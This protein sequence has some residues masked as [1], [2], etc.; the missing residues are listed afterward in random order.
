MMMRKASTRILRTKSTAI[1]NNMK[2][3]NIDTAYQLMKKHF[4]E[5]KM[6]SHNIR[7]AHGDM[8]IESEG[9]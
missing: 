7:D 8:L 3:G 9:I 2:K 5:R 1:N 4:R 6:K